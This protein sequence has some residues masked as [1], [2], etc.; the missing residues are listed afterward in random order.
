MNIPF[1]SGTKLISYSEIKENDW[2]VF[3]GTFISADNMILRFSCANYAEIYINGS[4]AFRFGERS[5]VFDIPYL[6]TD[7]SKYAKP[8]NNTI[9]FLY[10]STGEHDRDGIV[11]E[12]I[13]NGN[14]ILKS[15]KNIHS[16]KFF[17]Y[18]SNCNFYIKGQQSF[19]IY[20]SN[21]ETAFDNIEQ[22][23]NL[24]V[25]SDLK[26]TKLTNFHL[27]KE[28][29]PS[30]Q[31]V[32]PISDSS[33]L[34]LDVSK[35]KSMSVKAD[36]NKTYGYYTTYLHSN[37]N[38][39][40]TNVFYSSG[41]R[42]CRYGD[43][44]ISSGDVIELSTK[45][46]HLTILGNPFNICFSNGETELSSQNGVYFDF[47]P[48]N[49]PSP[50]KKPFFPW[51]DPK[52]E[53]LF[54]P[55]N[56]Q[57]CV[58]TTI[59][60]IHDNDSELFS[61]KN[62]LSGSS[63]I[64]EDGKT[65]LLSSVINSFESLSNK[66]NSF[67][68]APSQYQKLIVFDFGCVKIGTLGFDVNTVKNGKIKIYF[69]ETTD[70]HSFKFMSDRN[71]LLYISNGEQSSFESHIRRG[72][73]YVAFIFEKNTEYELSNI[74][75]TDLSHPIKNETY[76]VSSDK[77]LNGIY[78]M[79]LN[80]AKSCTLDT[81]VDCPAYEQ[82]PWTGDAYVT[83]L[84]NLY[85]F[86][87]YG[88]D[89]HFHNLISES[90]A[91]DLTKYYR[92]N[93]PRYISRKFL[94]CACFP[95]YPEGN[96]PIWSF[97][98]MLSVY[99]HYCLTGDIDFMKEIL[100]VIEETLTRCESL[101]SKRNLLS[102]DGAWNLIEWANNDLPPCGEIT[103]NN[104]LLHACYEKYSE[105]E[106]L[107]GN[108]PLSDH[109]TKIASSIKEAINKYAYDEE[110]EAY[111][112]TVRDDYGYELY[113][114]YYE[115]T[116]KEY[117]DFETYL[118]KTKYSV[119]TN[120]LA[121]YYDIVPS[122]KAEKVS[123][124]LVDNINNGEYVPGTPANCRLNQYNEEYIPSGYV[125]I[126]SPFFLFYAYKTL[127]KIGRFDLLFKSLKR[128]YGTLYEKGVFNT[129]EVFITADSK[130]RSMCHSWS[131]SPAIFIKT[132]IIG[133]KPLKPGF[134]EFTI[135]PNLCDLSY[136]KCSVPTP[137]GNIKIEITKE[138][139][140]EYTIICDS[141]EECVYLR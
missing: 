58:C 102:I 49:P 93:N 35:C 80:T 43:K 62:I 77:I 125:H 141:P 137:Y 4:F 71:E 116:N 132:S 97:M 129:P 20:D 42:L 59:C 103:A 113:K 68:I 117:D 126:G 24:T 29:L 8:G 60:E 95:T 66:S 51:N 78:E 18:T 15:D 9:S 87:E 32:L 121:V 30:E 134:R 99:D 76:F 108:T 65:E 52:T 115:R 1:Q 140:G 5:Y 36:C 54:E 100:P 14:C 48:S 39:Q 118:K 114:S 128:D 136:A 70:E 38:M 124:F 37:G 75:M 25:E 57:S 106:K 21:L 138:K 16:R 79:S 45:P 73:R 40:K 41:V 139:D 123:R 31:K 133:I 130:S 46:E 23:Q 10:C 26:N 74:H 69:F 85:N 127:E 3:T 105:I 27:S 13:S 120:T 47:V 94:P 34:Q 107:V 86:G 67:K 64:T 63:V 111:S 83:S 28:S 109:Y 11:F 119:Q 101:L 55:E 112:D 56:T 7:I 90:M 44:F 61:D 91:D 135:T 96:I 92:T 104:I 17:P 19:E 12:I 82:N 84:I 72:F 89:R 81:Y 98:W 53:V 122:E 33:C 22:A 50:P 110:K 2:F 6:E 88:L 131:A